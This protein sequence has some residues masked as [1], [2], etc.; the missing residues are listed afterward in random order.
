MTEYTGVVSRGDCRIA[1]CRRLFPERATRAC[2]RCGELV[3]QHHAKAWTS[4]NPT[5]GRCVR[6]ITETWR[7]R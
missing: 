3:C 7:T 5:C 6:E 1:A 4:P 2:H